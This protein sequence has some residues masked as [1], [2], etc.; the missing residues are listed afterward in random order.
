MLSGESIALRAIERGDLAQLLE[1]RNRPDFRRYYREYRELG[2]DQQTRWYEQV[3]LGDPGV[4]MFSI[5]ERATGTLLGACGICY[6][7]WVDRSGDISI[8]IGAD[9]LYID[10]VLAPDA[11]RVLL[12]YGFQE[13]NLH[14]IWAEIY[15]IDEKKQAFFKLLGFTLDGRHRETH[16]T[17]GGW[18]DSLFYGL[19]AHE[20]TT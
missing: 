11:A 5:V 12:R 14:R 18:R 3:V 9:G 19:L 15:D 20:F 8:Y 7:N 17:E 13:L 4:R 2:M 10:D 16:W 1:W 6:I